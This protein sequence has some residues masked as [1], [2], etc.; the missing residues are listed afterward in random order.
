MEL[1]NEKR[2][3]RTKIMKSLHLT[4]KQYS[5]LMKAEKKIEKARKEDK[6]FL[7]RGK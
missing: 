1:V 6:N 2:R 3:A 7:D 5:K 4:G